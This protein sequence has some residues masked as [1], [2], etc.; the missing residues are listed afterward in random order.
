MPNLAS[1]MIL[2]ISSILRRCI[3]QCG[4]TGVLRRL[5]DGRVAVVLR[6][7]AAHFSLGEAS[8][9]ALAV[10]GSFGAILTVV[11][12]SGRVRAGEERGVG[13]IRGSVDDKVAGRTAA[14]AAAE[15]TGAE[16]R[17][18][19]ELALVRVRE[20]DISTIGLTVSK[21]EVVYDCEERPSKARSRPLVERKR[22]MS[23]LP[24][25]PVQGRRANG[26]WGR[27]KSFP[28]TSARSAASQL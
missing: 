13:R 15:R 12:L 16:A 28:R 19:I 24:R 14:A 25:H 27:K 20:S 4:Q 5:R 11:E 7:W 23:F 9:M 18:T 8:D 17:R 3:P 21:R 1:L 26:L 22:V 6:R 10:Y 2:R